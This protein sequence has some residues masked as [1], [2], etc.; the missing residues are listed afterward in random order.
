MKKYISFL[1]CF[2]LI[3]TAQVSLAAFAGGGPKPGDIYKEYVFNNGSSNWRVTDPNINLTRFPAAAPFLPNPQ[4]NINID[5]LQGAVKA[6]VLIDFWGGHEGTVDKKFRFNNNSWINIPELDE[7]GG[8]PPPGEKYM[9]QL[10]H[11]IE[12]PLSQLQTGNNILQGTC[13]P[14]SWGWGQWAWYGITVRIYYDSSK[15]HATGQITSPLPGSTFGDNPTIT[16]ATS[17]NVARVDFLAYYEGYD[18]DGDGIFLDWQ[19]N[20]HREIWDEQT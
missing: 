15:P 20:Y 12:V 8:S 4:L 13:G 11:L 9:Q 19:R 7:L 16:A 2:L 6:E 1:I 18:S 5:D 17:G 3:F 14:N 10:N